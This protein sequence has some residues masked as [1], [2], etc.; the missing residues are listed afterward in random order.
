MD[1]AA[2]VRGLGR[3]RYEPAFRPLPSCVSYGVHL[4]CRGC[5]GIQKHRA[6]SK[7]RPGLMLA[8]AAIIPAICSTRSS[9]GAK[10][11]NALPR[12]LGRKRGNE[13]LL[14]PV[15]RGSAG[16]LPSLWL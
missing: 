14:R 2:W 7:I 12:L 6:K 8:S 5:G 15:R 16:S 1:V 3:E 13:A 10:G 4:V 9:R 11:P